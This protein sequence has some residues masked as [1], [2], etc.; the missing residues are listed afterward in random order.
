MP[1]VAAGE[2]ITASGLWIG[3]CPHGL[4]VK[5]ELPLALT[6]DRP[7]I[8]EDSL[9][10]PVDSGLGMLP[11]T[12]HGKGHVYHPGSLK[13]LIY[14]I[15]FVHQ[16]LRKGMVPRR[17]LVIPPAKALM[18]Q[19][20]VTCPAPLCLPVLSTGCN[21]ASTGS[22]LLTSSQPIQRIS[23]SSAAIAK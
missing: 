5:A 2:W 7:E 19:G 1:A 22:E 20:S 12:R 6:K 11:G 14:P 3:G 9:A 16:T 10:E 8:I 18:F 13:A 17:G 15:F 4:R 21:Q 23:A